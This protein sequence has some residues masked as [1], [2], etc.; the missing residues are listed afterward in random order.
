MP[1]SNAPPALS[2]Q[3]EDPAA[4][5]ISEKTAEEKVR[6]ESSGSSMD[7]I[8]VIKESNERHR[9]PDVPQSREPQEPQ[10]P[11]LS[12][13]YS[14]ASF[15]SSSVSTLVQPISSAITAATAAQRS[16]QIDQQLKADYQSTKLHDADIFVHG[17]GREQCIKTVNAFRA[18]TVGN[19]EEELLA[20]KLDV[21]RYLVSIAR[22]LV[23]IS[24]QGKANTNGNVVDDKFSALAKLLDV[25]ENGD[26][27]NDEMEEA[28]A[29]DAMFL[30][31]LEELW[32]APNMKALLEDD[33][34]HFDTDRVL[35]SYEYFC[36]NLSRIRQSAYAPNAADVRMLPH[37][38]SREHQ[39]LYLDA[40][41][42]STLIPP[43]PGPEPENQLDIRLWLLRDSGSRRKYLHHIH[44][45]DA[46]MTVV[47]LSFYNARLP[48]DPQT[49]MLREMMLSFD[50]T[51]KSRLFKES[52]LI[53]LLV[54]FGDFEGT[55]KESPMKQFF[56]EYDGGHDVVEA[57]KF[58]AGKFRQFLPEGR[59][60]LVY[61]MSITN[62]AEYI[63]LSVPPIERDPLH[64]L[65]FLVALLTNA[66]FDA[67]LDLDTTLNIRC[68]D[69]QTGH[70]SLGHHGH[71]LD[72][73]EY[74]VPVYTIDY[75]HHV[76]QPCPVERPILMRQSLVVFTQDLLT[77]PALRGASD[78]QHQ[79]AAVASSSS[80][81]KCTKFLETIK[82]PYTPKCYGSYHE[83][84][85][86]P[87]VDIVYVATPHSHHF[88]NAMLAL[89]AGKNVLCEKA[90]T[91][92]ANQTR[93]LVK[94][95]RE[96]G[97]FMMEA[98]WTRFF[99]LSKTVRELAS[100]GTVGPVY[101][102][103]ADL[104]FA[105]DL[106]GGKLD[107]ADSHRMVN[108]NL[109]GGA[110][111]DIGIY[112]LTWLM[113]ILY[114]CQPETEKEKPKVVAMMNKYHTGADENTTVVIQFEKHGSMGVGTSCL[115]VDTDVAN[116][117]AGPA[118]RIQGPKGEVQV[119][120]PAYRPLEYRIIKDAAG[121][122]VES[123]PCPI[124]EDPERD[125]WGHGMFWEAD[126][127]ARCIRDGKKESD[128]LPLDES[129][130]IMEIME[131]ALKQGG[132]VYPDIISSDVFE[133]H[134]KLN[135]GR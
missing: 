130:V 114:H 134:G 53:L 126:E 71:W 109:A 10:S 83:L 18:S 122:K 45:I 89:K 51:S 113:Q 16:H 50:S 67:R 108:P 40:T 34:G 12:N 59:E 124:P 54:D 120:G 29:E 102:V 85:A 123:F 115:R 93:L 69:F 76:S 35:R 111:L 80:V 19:T 88:Q 27:N 48:E 28:L 39:R 125:G 121:G 32:K 11:L 79:I 58:V 132:V 82:C 95:A 129:I 131:E 84:V 57:T 55:L 117:A 105:K 98:V 116:Q 46:I 17:G 22:T 23:R 42:S 66:A 135:T 15:L 43:S 86:D 60:A 63:N 74:A 56:A 119:M 7:S 38:E 70:P 37:G 112:S 1:D 4:A 30:D 24:R 103:F 20:F 62:E 44:D 3:Q 21:R 68:H 118:I 6:R 36:N 8:A 127:C 13:I 87:D 94:E 65:P 25:V 128:T 110:M 14:A 61:S 64:S 9:T 26:G 100:S 31:T 91:V 72:R 47:N 99:P 5:S 107:F 90:F 41:L 81:N 104:S 33:I 49:T 75:D 78:I 52:A 101:R 133:E 2:E 96:Q 77:N 73:R 97:V 92:T 106:P